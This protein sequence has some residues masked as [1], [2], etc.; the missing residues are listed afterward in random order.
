MPRHK[1]AE[2]RMRQSARRHIR[3]KARLSRMKTLI[4]KVRAAKE[5]KEA[6]TALKNA[7]QYLDRLAAKGVIHRNKAANQKSKLTR[8]VKAVK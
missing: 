2:K 5:K 4:K 8:F 7:V 6:E 1:S 3:N